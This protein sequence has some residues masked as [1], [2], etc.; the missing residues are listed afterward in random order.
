MNRFA[1][2]LLIFCAAAAAVA[3]P[4]Q[5]STNRPLEIATRG[6]KLRGTLIIPA[7]GAATHAALVIAPDPGATRDAARPLAQA[8]VD[9]GVAAFIYDAPGTG[10]S[11]GAA[12][13]AVADLA[14]DVVAAAREVGW[15]REIRSA[16]VRVFAS[17]DSASAAVEAATRA[18]RA[19]GY[20]ILQ[21][22]AATPAWQAEASRVE[23]QLRQGGLGDD[24]V[25]AAADFMKR[26]F[27]VARGGEGWDALQAAA[28]DPR[29]ARWIPYAKLPATLEQ[30]RSDWR[31]KFYYDPLP[32]IKKLRVPGLFVFA[33]DASGQ[34]EEN[35]KLL[36]AS[37]PRADDHRIVVLPA[38]AAAPEYWLAMTEYVTRRLEQPRAG[39]PF[40]AEVEAM[41]RAMEEAIVRDP[42]SVAKFYRDDASMRGPGTLVRGRST[43]E[44]YWGSLKDVRRWKLEVL[45]VAGGPDVV[46]Q[47]GRS[48]LRIGD[49][50]SVVEF[51]L[52]WKRQPD[53]KLGIALDFYY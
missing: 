17:G 6:V 52:L 36:R 14:T 1:M 37:L 10:Q 26:M 24:D 49:H 29:N 39:E 40:R 20:L 41:N 53:G 35:M 31:T 19:I 21:S 22:F 9:R 46:H 16:E 11:E 15:Q 44:T 2:P 25:R 23:A 7:D 18:P 12:A 38:T 32:A 43:F 34:A 42:A 4:P 45:D 8:F 3:A 27:D 33:G 50:D 13:A 30:L 51:V 47:R 48:L 28:A 5:P